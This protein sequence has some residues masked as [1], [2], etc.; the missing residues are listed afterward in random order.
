MDDLA[1]MAQF[2]IALASE[3]ESLELEPARVRAG[4]EALL[5]DPAKGTYFVAASG[6]E[7]VG[8]LLITH[9][10]SDW[11]NGD[12]WWLQ[13]VYVR[14]DFRRRGVF[15][16][17]FDFVQAKASGAPDVCGLRLYMEENNSR[18]REAYGSLGMSETHYRVFER[19]FPR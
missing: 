13:S 18:A 4:V 2:N 1:V 15:K 8:Q 3:S 17:L 10:W 16:A 7:V 9:E 14:P 6:A 11:R 12:F 5:R 19:L